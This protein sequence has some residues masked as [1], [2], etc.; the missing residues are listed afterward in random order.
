MRASGKVKGSDPNLQST[1]ALTIE[2]RMSKVNWVVTNVRNFNKLDPPTAATD[3]VYNSQQKHSTTFGRSG[4]GNATRKTT[5]DA[6]RLRSAGH[7]QLELLRIAY[8]IGTS[9]QALRL[10]W[11]RGSP[12][13]WRWFERVGLRERAIQRIGRR[14][15]L[16]SA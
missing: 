2:Q 12:I 14:E 8:G 1:G 15:P 5:G 7:V 9:C 16:G 4:H 11:Q 3:P 13:R 10:D 6:L